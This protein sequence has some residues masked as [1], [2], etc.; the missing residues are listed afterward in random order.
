VF[1]NLFVTR[2][3]Y[4][5]YNIVEPLNRLATQVTRNNIL[6]AQETERRCPCQK[7]SESFSSDRTIAFQLKAVVGVRK[8]N[9]GSCLSGTKVKKR[10]HNLHRVLFYKIIR[11]H[12][13]QKIFPII[14][15]LFAH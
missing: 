3:S 11:K 14:R 1:R 10:L 15:P 4:T 8:N 9:K 13:K 6:V 5:R 2:T 12:K 7:M